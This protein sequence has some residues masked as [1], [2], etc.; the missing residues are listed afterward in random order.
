METYSGVFMELELH[1]LEFHAI[2]LFLFLFFKFHRPI[3]DFLPI[4]FFDS[5]SILIKSSF[6]TGARI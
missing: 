1:E 6:K 2:F 3:L 4:E 5:N